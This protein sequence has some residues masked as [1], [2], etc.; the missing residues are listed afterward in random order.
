MNNT[1]P[2][3]GA[4]YNVTPKDIGRRLKC[5]KCNAALMVTDAGLIPDSNPAAQPEEPPMRAS[6]LPRGKLFDTAKIGG[7]PGLLFGIGVVFVLF[8]TFMQVLSAAAIQRATEYEKK[9]SLEE[10]IRVRKLLPKGKKDRAELTTDEQKAFD[11]AK[12][13]VEDEY[14]IPK[15]EADE[16]RRYTEIANKRTR[17]YEGYGT[18]IG[19]VFL[20][21]GCLGFLRAQEAMLL[22]V[23]AGI[24]LTGMVL[25]LFKLAIGAGAGI[26]AAINLG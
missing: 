1:C 11:E 19:F 25:G 18:M 9:L 22:R 26:G 24:I 8:F 14:V 17:L 7:M 10:E 21:F 16:E 15:K 12:K 2:A 5:K 13:K 3:C 23:V 6:R 20:A 4:L